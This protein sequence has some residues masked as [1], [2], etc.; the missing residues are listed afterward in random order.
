MRRS[1][2]G[3]P[4]RPA[5]CGRHRR[6]G[7]RCVRRSR[8]RPADPVGVFPVGLDGARDLRALAGDGR[9]D[10]QSSRCARRRPR[11]GG[12]RSRSLR[13]RRRATT[14]RRSRAVGSSADR[15]GCAPGGGRGRRP[16]GGGWCRQRAEVSAGVE[17]T[18][19]PVRG[20]VRDVRARA[21][22]RG[23]RRGGSGR[24]PAGCAAP[25]RPSTG[26]TW[27]AH[28]AGPCRCGRVGSSGRAAVRRRVTSVPVGEVVA[29][30]GRA[31][32]DSAIAGLAVV[33]EVA[34]S[35]RT[36]RGS[37]RPARGAGER[38]TGA[39]GGGDPREV[40]SRA[41]RG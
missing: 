5:A 1:S 6:A 28:E 32:R 34:E 19:P 15:S 14:R 20:G 27:V 26:A 40:R 41:G 4:L 36:R 18:E 22:A 9:A 29:S 35:R 33:A 3:G 12:R 2:R 7:R 11:G 17:V 16:G 39:R 10:E 31:V 25:S 37:A 23:S 30:S 38:A 8:G 13:G 24:R 21:S